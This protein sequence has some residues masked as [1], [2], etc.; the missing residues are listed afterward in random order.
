M[1]INEALDMIDHGETP[2]EYKKRCAK[3]RRLVFERDFLIDSIEL[4]KSDGRNRTKVKIK[5]NRLEKVNSMI[6]ELT[7]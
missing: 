2:E 6:E 4:L 5:E 7:R 1:N 3:I